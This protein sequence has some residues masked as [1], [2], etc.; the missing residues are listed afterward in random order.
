[1]ENKVKN[2]EMVGDVMIPQSAFIVVLLSEGGRFDPKCGVGWQVTEL[3]GE[4]FS[5]REHHRAGA[6]GPRSMVND[7]G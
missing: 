1:L 6:L 5:G 2:V 4:I 3:Q 7:V